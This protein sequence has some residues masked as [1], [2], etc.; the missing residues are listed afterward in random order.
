MHERG[1]RASNPCERRQWAAVTQKK[2]HIMADNDK[3]EGRAKQAGGKVQEVAG[4][5]TDNE[6]QE[7]EGLK[8]QAE[9]NV[10]EKW[11][12]AKDKGRDL[13]DKVRK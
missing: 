7:A 5:M 10:Q 6:E 3:W 2:E 1:L 8:K 4:R 13:A 12:E 11:G 9:G